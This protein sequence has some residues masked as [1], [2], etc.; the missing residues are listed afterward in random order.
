M[1]KRGLT[2]AAVMAALVLVLAACQPATPEPTQVPPTEEMEQEPTATEA[3]EESMGATVTVAE[4]EEFGAFL[5]DSEGMSLYLFTNDTENTSNCYDDCATN[6]PP[7]LTEGD[8]VAGEGVDESLLGTTERDDGSMQVTYNGWSLYYF[9]PDES[10]GDTKGQGV[11]DVWY[12]LTPEGEGIGMESMEEESMGTTVAVAENEEYGSVLV[13]SEGMSLYLFTNDPENTS[14]CYDDCATA[15]PPLLTEGDPVAGES[16]D[17]SLLGT[18]ERDDGSMQVTYNGWPLYY[19][20]QDQAAGDTEGQGVGDV[21]YLL[22]P[23]GEGIGMESMGSTVQVDAVDSAFDSKEVEV[24]VGTTVVWT[25]T[26]SIAHTV[27]ADDG[28]FDSGNMDSG[29]T[30]EY[31]FEEAGTYPYY[32]K[33]H[34]DKGGVG[35]AGVITVT[36]N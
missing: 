31:T 8:P 18:T 28:S 21:W 14:N 9:A 34:G 1:K 36:E 5:V 22:T 17:G 23:E 35:M 33:Y 27:T 24:S 7:L 4:N 6:W 26:G 2:L 16:V 29:D 19:F 20:A 13:D 10:A 25:N 32:C 15:W 30:F 3:M 12:L 11:G